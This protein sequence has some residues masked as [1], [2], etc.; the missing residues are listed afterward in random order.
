MKSIYIRRLLH[1]F[2]QAYECVP[3]SYTLGVPLDFT[4]TIVYTIVLYLQIGSFIT[5]LHTSLYTY[6]YKQ[7]V[8]VEQVEQVEQAEQAE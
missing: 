1:V 3:W 4:G 5:L 7:V 8:Q 6:E 2:L